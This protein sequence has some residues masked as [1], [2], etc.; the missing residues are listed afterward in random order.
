MFSLFNPEVS[1]HANIIKHGDFELADAKDSPLIKKIS[2]S[3]CILLFMISS[4]F[5]ILSRKVGQ[6]SLSFFLPLLEFKYRKV[7][8]V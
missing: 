6:V 8:G 4:Q 1:R 2:I 5:F 7:G 3:T